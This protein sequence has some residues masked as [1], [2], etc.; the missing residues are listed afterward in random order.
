ML[1]WP[2]RIDARSVGTGAYEGLLN[3]KG[4][5][6]GGRGIE[7][8]CWAT[9]SSEAVRKKMVIADPPSL[10]TFA[11]QERLEVSRAV[12]HPKN[13]YSARAR[14]VEHE[15]PVEARYSEDSQR[16]KT[17]VP[18]PTMPS[19]LRLCRKEGK[20]LMGSEEKPVTNLGARLCGKTIGLV[21]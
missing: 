1:L 6:P 20:R 2:G 9:L 8:A 5:G 10:N 7:G 15:H 17:R 3:C 14:A 12:D 13:L 19:H 18:E 4:W 11:T 16:C 21:V